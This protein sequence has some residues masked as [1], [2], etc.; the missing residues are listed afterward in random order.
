MR[1]ASRKTG[2]SWRRT[3]ASNALASPGLPAATSSASGSTI[4][5]YVLDL[6]R[7]RRS[8]RVMLDQLVRHRGISSRW[9]TGP[10]ARSRGPRGSSATFHL[11]RWA[12]PAPG[13][14]GSSLSASPIA[15]L[16]AALAHETHGLDDH[17]AV[18]RLAHVV[19]GE[20]RR[21]DR[22]QRLHLDA[23]ARVSA[24]R[25]S[26]RTREPR[27]IGQQL[28]LDGVERQGVAQRNPLVGALG[29]LHPRDPR[30][31][32]HVALRQRARRDRASVSGGIRTVAA[33]DA[34]AP[35]H[36]LL[37]DVDH[38]RATL[39]VEV[40]ELAAPRAPPTPAARLDPREHVLEDVLLLGL[41]ED[42]VA[43]ARI[44]GSAAAR[45]RAAREAARSGHR[46]ESD[47]LRRAASAAAR[48]RAPA[49]R[50][51]C[52]R[53]RPSARRRAT[54][55]CL[56]RRRADRRG[57][58]ARP[59]DRS[60]D[61]RHRGPRRARAAAATRRSARAAR[62]RCARMPRESASAAPDVTAPQTSG[63]R[64][65]SERRDD[66]P[67]HA[68]AQQVERAAGCSARTLASIASRSSSNSAKRSTWPRSP[69]RA[70][71]TAMIVGVHGAA[72]RREPGADV[73][74]AAAVLGEAVH[75]QQHALGLR[76]RHARRN[77]VRPLASELGFDAADA[78]RL[79]GQS[80]GRGSGDRR[81]AQDSACRRTA[82]RAPAR[83]R[84][85]RR[86]GCR[87]PRSR[88]RC[89]RLRPGDGCCRRGGRQPASMLLSIVVRLPA[90]ADRHDHVRHDLHQADGAL[91]AAR[92]RPR[93]A[94]DE[95]HGR[96]QHRIDPVLRAVADDRRRDALEPRPARARGS[97][98]EAQPRSP[99]PRRR[100]SAPARGARQRRRRPSPTS[101]TAS[102][103]SR[104]TRRRLT[105]ILPS[106]VRAERAA[107]GGG[108]A[109]VPS[110][111][112][113]PGDD[114]TGWGSPSGA[115]A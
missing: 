103:T 64:S 85:R 33:R 97:P 39:R 10:Q 94:L 93:A 34:L 77:S 52:A 4:S 48:A 102:R 63:A 65:Q 55:S 16:A 19:D 51:A 38:A 29:G 58:R 86:R 9:D 44:G 60:R 56:P 21:R 54:S 109:N 1:S 3:S 87:S 23:G 99:A 45:A 70:A 106:R 113:P 104:A 81:G 30:G 25:A 12:R 101:S 7:D 73:V 27:G 80:P 82:S 20:P 114:I 8:G 92:P 15:A 24:T 2:R 13:C 6:P 59:R 98:R 40:G 37:G 84:G 18:D 83:E 111:S 36:R 89:R 57:R 105:R 107:R 32:E 49:L 72:A 46:T 43:Q 5:V 78:A 115:G 66:E 75:E 41:V 17:A 53:P 22:D 100:P 26:I 112:G 61:P 42:L 11:G 76:R 14:A 69:V 96:H 95:H 50:G 35:R 79:P 91:R 71:V 67:A 108:A 31:R 90:S 62:M 28:D 88:P 74:V 68:V 47:R 110:A